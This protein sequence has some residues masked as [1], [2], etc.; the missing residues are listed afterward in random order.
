M[1]IVSYRLLAGFFRLIS[2]VPLRLL[3]VAGKL[4]GNILWALNGR[5]RQTSE[6]NIQ[7][8]FP[9]MDKNQQSRL[10]R[11]SMQH[12]GITALE[13]AYV[14]CRSPQTNLSR[15]MQVTGQEHLSAAVAEGRGVIV[16]A[17]HL[18]NW[19]FIGPYLGLHYQATLMYQPAKRPAL[20]KIIFDARENTGAKL[21]PTNTSG[22][23]A[24][25][26]AL[27]KGGV[28][29]ILADQEPPVESGAY[30]PFFG[31][32][33]LTPTMTFSLLSR[34]GAKVVMA[35]A[36]RIEGT[37]DFVLVIEPADEGIYSSDVQVSLA[38][39]NA[40]IERCI[41][42]APE[43]YQWEY[44]RFKRRPDGNKKFYP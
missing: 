44:K 36:K 2:W 10:V 22:V 39:M 26:R 31:I 4:L 30:A 11:H 5:A 33:T 17:P 34:T 41:M 7:V 21:V 35:Y 27:K 32:P 14:W 37:G 18:G 29:G 40:G 3:R 19:E 12:L 28:V 8:C 6:K 15:I 20:N 1:N 9:Q 13:M 23:K 38:A 24:Q 16:L 25:W 43:Q 42:A